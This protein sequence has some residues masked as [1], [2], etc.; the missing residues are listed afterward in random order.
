MPPLRLTSLLQGSLAHLSPTSRAVVSTLSCRNGNAPPAGDVAAW[1]GLRDRHQLARILQRD[2]LPSLRE[3]AGWTRVLYWILEA[4]SSGRSLLQLAQ[5]ERVD[6][7]VAYRLVRRVTGLRWSQVRRAGLPNLLG[8]FADRHPGNGVGPGAAGTA[9]SRPPAAEAWRRTGRE[10]PLPSVEIT[11]PRAAATA[12]RH[13]RGVLAGR[14]PVPG[15]PFDV[16][17]TTSGEMC[18]T[19]SH[20]AAVDCLRFRPSW[21]GII[22][23]IATGPVPTRLVCNPSGGWGYV[24]LQFADQVGVI[25]LVRHR[26]VRVIPVPGNPLGAGVSADGR[27]LFVTTNVDLLCRIDTALEKVTGSVPIPQAGFD[28]A[29][30]P[31]APLLYVSTWKAGR[32]LEVDA[33]TL[34]TVRVFDVGGT[35]QDLVVAPDGLKLYATNEEGWLDLVSLRTGRRA[36]RADLGSPAISLAVTRDGALLYVGL[37]VAGRVV[38]L[39]REALTPVATLRTGGRPRRIAFDRGGRAAFIANEDGWVDLVM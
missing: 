1:V 6:P 20:A 29:F 30:H 4:E 16:T 26:L 37:V 19:R 13:P 33:R 7:A 18:V 32:I 22:D 9:R 21:L 17:A 35:V 12:P 36:A 39:D 11:I 28:L 25:D 14:V 5:R 15:S 8:C 23:R 24:T 38:V 31:S 3:L 10:R 34:R 2:G 27:T